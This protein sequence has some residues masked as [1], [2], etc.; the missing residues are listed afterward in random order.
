[1]KAYIYKTSN[2]SI[3]SGIVREFGSLDECIRTLMMETKQKTYTVTDIKKYRGPKDVTGCS[4]L[5]EICDIVGEKHAGRQN[6]QTQARK[7]GA[8]RRVL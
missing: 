4:W 8:H 2:S 3:E 5:V 7:T 6:L 1:M